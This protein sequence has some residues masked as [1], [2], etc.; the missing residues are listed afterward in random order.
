MD[1]DNVAKYLFEMGQMKRVKRSGWW[2]AGISNPES[3]AE[4][5]FRTA[6]IGYI[7]ASLAEADPAKTALLCLFH[8]TGEARINDFH[9]V[10]KRYIDVGKGE[11]KA[12]HEQTAR[13]PSEI[14]E[15]ITA[16]FEEY[17]ERLSLEGKLAH[18]AD[19]LECLIQ[20][21]E[22]QQ[23]GYVAVDD[24]ITNC[25]AGLQTEVAKSV[26]DACLRTE[27][28]GWWQGLKII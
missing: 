20:A 17:E 1:G 10:A 27:P 5:S 22:Y 3:I 8:D 4:H 26:A 28:Y 21:R 18:D 9:R 19:L 11:E 14:A 2:L 16:F 7:L 6:I 13:L 15:Q 25:F 24:W 12:I 23:Q